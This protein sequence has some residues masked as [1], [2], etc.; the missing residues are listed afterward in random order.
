ET[1]VV[2][3]E[4]RH[5]VK[6]AALLP[7]RVIETLVVHR[8]LGKPGKPGF[9][10]ERVD[11]ALLFVD[12]SG[13]TASMEM[14][15][16]QG[17][18]GIEK[19]WKM[20]NAYFCDLLD[21]I[22]GTG[23]DIDCFAGDAI[24]VVYETQRLWER[25]GELVRARIQTIDGIP[26]T[27]LCLATMA[28]S[29]CG[30]RLLN[31]LSPYHFSDG[32]VESSL[33]LH[34]SIGAGSLRTVNIGGKTTQGDNS[35]AT[36]VCGSVFEQLAVAHDLSGKSEFCLSGEAASLTGHWLDLWDHPEHP[37]CKI[38][39]GVRDLSG[40]G[41]RQQE[42]ASPTRDPAQATMSTTEENGNSAT[43][44]GLIPAQ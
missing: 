28:A 24:L 39:K 40:V 41:Q 31:G 30:G 21:I 32:A 9:A 25:T 43:V 4:Y 14:F 11:A 18:Q 8:R 13:F 7:Q 34:G 36:F 29:Q 37:T 19:F 6:L 20:F 27:K 17:S 44:Q 22:Q 42:P 16:R 10:M 3:S 26:L 35:F 12:I 15:A 33:T 5:L 1:S 38:L 23:G 2:P